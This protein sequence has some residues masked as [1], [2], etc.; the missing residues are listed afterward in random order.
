MS[1]STITTTVRVSAAILAA[2]EA[3]LQAARRSRVAAIDEL[4]A[5]ACQ[6]T[7]VD[8]EAATVEARLAV[9][10]DGDEDILD[11]G[12]QHRVD[13]ARKAGDVRAVESALREAESAQDV[14]FEQRAVREEVLRRVAGQMPGSL[15]PAV[16]EMRAAPSGTLRLE[17]LRPAGERLGVEAAGVDA[18]GNVELSFDVRH[19]GLH[20][21]SGSFA[22]QCAHEVEAVEQL[23][24]PLPAVGLYPNGLV[25]DGESV[26]RR[27]RRDDQTNG[28]TA[29]A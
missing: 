9:L 12:L 1:G 8:R 5:T 17:A 20:P 2:G 4:V 16:D 13:A 6:R 14:A 11:P 25:R 3:A 27:R 18:V 23:L 10:R 29:D 24:D 28:R 19:A 7:G 21:A 26:V 22:D 15:R